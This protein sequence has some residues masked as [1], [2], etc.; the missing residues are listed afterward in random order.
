MGTVFSIRNSAIEKLAVCMSEQ[1]D[2][3]LERQGIGT[4]YDVEPSVTI[5]DRLTSRFEPRRFPQR[6]CQPVVR[7][8]TLEQLRDL[9]FN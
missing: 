2:F 9:I 4:A 8:R 3:D 1:R 5:E 7:R 6:E